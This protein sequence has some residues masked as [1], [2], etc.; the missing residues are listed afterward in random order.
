M[1]KPKPK[2]YSQNR[3]EIVCPDMIPRNL[4]VKLNG[5]SLRNIESFDIRMP[6]S[7]GLLLV[8]IK[9]Y[10]ALYFEGS[11]RWLRHWGAK[12]KQA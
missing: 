10:S 9:F 6:D 7:E 8:S 5:K 11:S 4:K 2:K 12:T 1:A 3:L